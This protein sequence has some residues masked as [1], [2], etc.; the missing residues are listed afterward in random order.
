MKFRFAFLPLFAFL[1]PAALLADGPHTGRAPVL[2][3]QINN[4]SDVRLVLNV[5]TD[6]EA[7]LARKDADAPEGEICSATLS[8]AGLEA[9][10]NAL[11]EAGALHL[12]DA[13]PVPNVTRKT[14]TFFIGADQVGRTRGN[15]FSYFRT[16]GPYLPVARALSALLANFE[17]C[18]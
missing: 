4:G 14:I 5:Y 16:E 13:V 1:L 2:V 3:A 11:H 8:A 9:L 12:G 15:T 18:I 10:E 17:D 6:G 7:V